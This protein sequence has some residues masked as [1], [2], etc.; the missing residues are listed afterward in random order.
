MNEKPTNEKENDDLNVNQRDDLLSAAKLKK[1]EVQSKNSKRKKTWM[2][3][4]RHKGKRKQAKSDITPKSA[5][6][7]KSAKSKKKGTEVCC[8][9]ASLHNVCTLL[10]F[11]WKLIG[12]IFICSQETKMMLYIAKLNSKMM[13]ATEMKFWSLKITM[14]LAVL[15]SS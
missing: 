6:P 15:L 1:K 10:S 8:K 3:K 13:A 12:S 9:L 7:T 4:F 11:Q 2:D 5:I 14:S